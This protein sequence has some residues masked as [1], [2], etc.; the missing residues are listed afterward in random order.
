MLA[1]Q[2]RLLIF[3]SE[4]F[5]AEALSYLLHLE[6]RVGVNL[7][8]GSGESLIGI[9][10][11]INLTITGS[12]IL[13]ISSS[14]LEIIL[15]LPNLSSVHDG[16]VSSSI[17]CSCPVL[18]VINTTCNSSSSYIS[19]HNMSFSN[20]TTSALWAQN[21]TVTLNR[22][23]FTSMQ[24]TGPAIDIVNNDGGPVYVSNC[25]FSNLTALADNSS[26]AIHLHSQHVAIKD[27][28]FRSCTSSDGRAGAVALFSNPIS[29]GTWPEYFEMNISNCMFSNNSG[30]AVFYYGSRG[31]SSDY[32]RLPSST[33]S[34]NSAYSG[35]AVYAD[36]TY[37]GVDSCLFE[38]NQCAKGVGGALTFHGHSNQAGNV[39]LLNSSLVG[40]LVA[41][42]GRLY[43]RY[44]S[45]LT[46]YEQ[47]AG[48]YFQLGLCIGV[49]GCTFANNQ[50]AGLCVINYS[51]TCEQAPIHGLS[52]SVPYQDTESSSVYQQL[53][54][55]D[56][57]GS[58]S[59]GASLT[60]FLGPLSIS[61]DVRNSVFTGNDA[62]L[63]QW[64]RE[65][66]DSTGMYWLG[67]IT[68][69]AGVYLAQITGGIFAN[70]TAAN[71]TASSGAA[72]YL[73][74]CSSIVMWNCLFDSNVVHNDGGA[75][76]LADNVGGGAMIGNST[77]QNN[78]AGGS[79][80][81]FA[82]AS[83]S[84]LIITNGTNLTGNAAGVRGGAFS[85]DSCKEVTI[86]LG[87][88]FEGNSAGSFGGA[89]DLVNTQLLQIGLSQILSNRY[90]AC[91][92][93]I[94]G[95]CAYISSSL[96]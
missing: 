38:A 86:Q 44:A 36:L 80:G 64:S 3:A 89:G 12:K 90:I 31:H 46:D 59:S 40:N 52:N 24:N 77:L 35:G 1:S 72:V 22:S 75:I 81:A 60:S 70:V 88:R 78:H 87:S 74:S 14:S 62:S 73:N 9:D 96:A 42:D 7:Q 57:V 94:A 5:H 33:F 27:S 43:D 11:P 30:G 4:I 8:P 37:M 92:A 41:D 61:I 49:Y 71:N 13:N 56:S 91:S 93:C 10:Q 21:S 95:V 83:P 32:L 68:G 16:L 6:C 53:F 26:A 69:G 85:C 51:G 45:E 76:F 20:S 25:T 47:C 79:G 15:F 17:H 28:I 18:F 39:L 29:D 23:T 58:M 66:Q 82:C 67:G 50:G 54:N 48:A 63:W 34:Q 84:S 2:V 19:I 65:Y 55:R